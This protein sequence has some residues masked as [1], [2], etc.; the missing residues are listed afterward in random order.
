MTVTST[1]PDPRHI[2]ENADTY[3]VILTVTD[4]GTPALSDT[5]DVSITVDAQ[6]NRR[7]VAV[8]DNCTCKWVR[9]YYL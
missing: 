6:P 9:E 4:D 7:P 2:F 5:A 1:E 3:N 8:N